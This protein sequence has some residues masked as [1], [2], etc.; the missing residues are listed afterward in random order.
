MTDLELPEGITAFE[1]PIPGIRVDTPAAQG[2]IYTNGAHVAEWTPAGASP[3]LWMSQSS[4]FEP[5]Q[6][7]RGG[8][9]I[10]WPWF[11]AGADNDKSPAHGFARLSQWHLR[12][13]EV[14]PSGVATLLFGLEG[15]EEPAP[16]ASGMPDD[17]TLK[18]QVSMGEALTVQFMVT[19]GASELRFE[20][21]L[22][23]YFAVGDIKKTR[24]EGLEGAAYSD[25]L[26]GRTHTQS[27]AVSFTGETDRVYESAGSAR[28]V[29]EAWGR[30]ILVEKVGS[31]QSVV[32]NPWINKAAAMPDF[33]DDEWPSMVC[34]EAVNTREQSIVVPAGGTH[35]LSQTIS[36]R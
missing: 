24:V 12:R 28:I 16:A 35:L 13:A 33:G 36:L 31:S 32:W 20:E 17:Y 25:R 9:P 18:L 22:H 8:I 34:V 27:G 30:T 1:T 26:T 23:S 14:S 3:V 2:V 7:I 19:A 4:V 11:G 10:V 21:G 6:A 5:G 29:D 15:R